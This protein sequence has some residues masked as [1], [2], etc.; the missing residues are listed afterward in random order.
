MTQRELNNEVELYD[1]RVGF[2]SDIH[3]G[4]IYGLTPE[5]WMWSVSSGNKKVAHAA[6][7]QKGIWE[8]YCREVDRLAPIEIL[9]VNG[10]AIDGKGKQSGGTEQLTSDR[11]VQT[12]MAVRCIERANA[13]RVVIIKGTP[14]HTGK[15]EDW[16]EIIADRVNAEACS[17][18]EYVKVNEKFIFSCRHY[19]G[20]SSV[21]HGQ[22]TPLLKSA[23]WNK[24][25]AAEYK[26][27]PTANIFIRSHVHYYM[28]VDRATYSAFILPA[29]QGFGSKFGV[30]KCENVVHVGLMYFDINADGRC[31]KWDKRLAKLN[32]LSVDTLSL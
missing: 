10:D 30:G 14:Y 2:I 23:D 1:K 27:F 28:G 17:L 13:K 29:L 3:C 25:W 21:S 12:D 5:E 32:C 24:L 11:K 15:E 8:W 9:V 19:I 4:N 18:H 20:G 31:V 6:R 26:E 7:V 16:E 22:A